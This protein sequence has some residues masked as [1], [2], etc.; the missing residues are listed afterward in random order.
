MTPRDTT[1]TRSDHLNIAAGSVSAVIA[2][3][4]LVQGDY[5]MAFLASASAAL[6]AGSTV[7]KFGFEKSKEG[8]QSVTRGIVSSGISIGRNVYSFGY[9][10]YSA[11]SSF[12]GR[13]KADG[14]KK[15]VADDKQAVVEAGVKPKAL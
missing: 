15:A 2:L 7:S 1:L 3:A 13:A 9:L 8:L 12:F 5:T 14:S 4:E 11:G 6:T 10:A